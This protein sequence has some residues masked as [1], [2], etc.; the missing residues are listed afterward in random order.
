MSVW[1]TRSLERDR[2]Y[3]VFQHSIKGTNH[4]I[5]GVKFR[6]G[7]AV[8]EKNSK[9]YYSLKKIPPLRDA[10]E[11]P[12]TY[13]TKLPFITRP[14]DIRTVYGQDVYARFLAEEEKAKVLQIE[15]EKQHKLLAEIQAN[16]QR[17]LELKVKEEIVQ[18]IEIALQDGKAEVV[19]EL[20][21][22]LP[23]IEKC[24]F[25]TPEGS[26]C[27]Q[28]AVEYSPSNYCG[29]HV[30]EDP[31]LAEFG[32]EKPNLMTKQEK[33]AFREKAKSVLQKAKDSGKF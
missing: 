29:Y 3:I 30:S 16:E 33:K 2:D 6:G 20:Q 21:K 13:L 10:K 12:I 26:L 28:G 18:K 22:S 15:Q 5:N 1:T 32:L 7:Y 31:R 9:V 4:I 14:N 11:F 17:E 19:N 27:N 24:S 23:S 8:V 25:R